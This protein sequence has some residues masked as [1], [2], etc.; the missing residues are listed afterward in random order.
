MRLKD[1]TIGAIIVLA[2]S[3]LMWIG[4]ILII[5]KLIKS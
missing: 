2:A 1:K 4:I 5:I 3:G